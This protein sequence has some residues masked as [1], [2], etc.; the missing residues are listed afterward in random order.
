MLRCCDEMQGQESFNDGG[1]Q[2]QFFRFSSWGHFVG[3]NIYEGVK[4]SS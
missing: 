1:A 3:M 4:R 2:I